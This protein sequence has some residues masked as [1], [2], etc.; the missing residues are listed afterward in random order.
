MFILYLHLRS[1]LAVRGCSAAAISGSRTATNSRQQTKSNAKEF[2]PKASQV[3]PEQINLL[4]RQSQRPIAH[5]LFSLTKMCRVQWMRRTRKINNTRRKMEEKEE[6]K[7]FRERR[8]HRSTRGIG[9][10]SKKEFSCPF[11]PCSHSFMAFCHDKFSV[12]ET[13]TVDCTTY[14]VVCGPDD[15]QLTTTPS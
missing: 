10:N 5:L 11:S 2:L 1:A 13:T 14:N 3:L 7:E 4:N 9:R 6:E 15:E 8:R 12:V